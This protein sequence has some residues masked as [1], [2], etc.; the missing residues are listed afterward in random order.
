MT[1]RK[2]NKTYTDILNRSMELFNEYGVESVSIFRVAE[3]LKISAGNLTY[4]FKRKQDLVG[5]LLNQLEQEMI[6][7]FKN[8]PYTSGAR[9]FVQAYAESFGTSWKYRGLFNSAPYLI[10][11]GLVKASRFR[12]LSS[13]IIATAVAQTKRL[14]AQGFMEKVPPPYNVNMLVDCIWWQW[15]GWLRVNQ[16]REPDE[17]IAF[18]DIVVSGISHSILLASPYMKKDYAAKLHQALQE[19]KTTAIKERRRLEK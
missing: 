8:F 13:H 7:G 1:T 11:S 15:L 2:A 10:Q 9:S 17:R 3:S 4:H 16:L 5:E 12:T 14:I 19:L 6:N 18:K